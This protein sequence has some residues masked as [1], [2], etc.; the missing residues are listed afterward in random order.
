[1]SI[2]GLDLGKRRIGVAIADASALGVRPLATLV[3]S[4]PARDFDALRNF[5]A[6]W[7]VERIVLGLPLNMNGSEGPAAR[8]AREFARRLSEVSAVPVDLYDERLTSF[9][10]ESRLKDFTS[11]RGPRKLM[12]D[13][14]AAALILEGWLAEHGAELDAP[15]RTA[16][17]A[18]SK[19]TTKV[20]C[21]EV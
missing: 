14:V 7:Q 6:D 21:R 19:Q 2:L 10:A 4:S 11:R 9:E 17:G 16:A 8:H 18:R 5:V 15:D 13:Q 20:S 1:M 3:R 12:V